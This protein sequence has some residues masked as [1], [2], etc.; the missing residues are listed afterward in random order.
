M[1]SGGNGGRDLGS[2]DNTNVI[3]QNWLEEAVP[4]ER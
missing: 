4:F 3:T 2:N 1:L